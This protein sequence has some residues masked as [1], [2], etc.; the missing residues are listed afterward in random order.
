MEYGRHGT[1]VEM[2][3]QLQ[4]ALDTAGEPGVVLLGYGLCG[5]GLAGLRAGR[6]TVVIP[7]TDDCIAILMGS[8]EQYLDDFHRHPGTYYLS[9]GWLESGFHPLGQL[10]EWSERHGEDK[11]RKLIAR[12]YT[13]YRRVVLVAFTPEE[14]SRYRGEARAVADLLGVAYDEML[15]ASTLL[16]RLVWQAG[17]PDPDNGEFVVVPPGET[18]KQMDFVR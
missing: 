14:L 10:Q 6:H 13:H 1:P 4:D 9:E 17:T 3:A 8:Y 15:G 18:V 2:K 5:N 16:E 7:R 11:A 12:V